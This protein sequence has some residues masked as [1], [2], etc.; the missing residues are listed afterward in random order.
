[1]PCAYQLY[2]YCASLKLRVIIRSIRPVTCLMLNVAS[3]FDI[4]HL[5][6]LQ[7]SNSLNN[8]IFTRVVFQKLEISCVQL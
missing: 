3:I 4:K 1:M 5:Q 8:K 6:V 7:A 2:K